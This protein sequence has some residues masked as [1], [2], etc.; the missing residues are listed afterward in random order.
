MVVELSPGALVAGRYRLD[1]LLGRGG[2]GQVWAATH[3]VTHRVAAL[4]LLNGPVH[5]QAGRRR[6]FLREARAAS[7]VNHPNVVRV[8]DFFELED[9]TPVMIMDL[10]EGETLGRRLGR[11]G[12]LTLETAAGI[13]LPVVSAVGTA[14]A[15]GIIHRDLKPENVFLSTLSSGAPAVHVLDFG[16]A[17]LVPF[18]SPGSIDDSDALTG[19]GGLMGTP[20]Y[21][22]PEQGFGEG[23]V[24]HRT[25][26]WS[27]GI[28]LY[29]ALAGSRPV[30]GANVGQVLKRLLS[31][32]ITPIEVLVSDL[33][34]EVS[35][36]V[37]RMLQ[38]DPDGRPRDLREVAAILSCHTTATAPPFEAAIGEAALSLDSSPTSAQSSPRAVVRAAEPSDPIAATDPVEQKVTVTAPSTAP[39]LGAVASQASAS[40][41]MRHRPLIALSALLLVVGLAAVWSLRSPAGSAAA[42]SSASVAP[43]AT[44]RDVPAVAAPSPVASQVEP[45]APVDGQGPEPRTATSSEGPERPRPPK[46]PVRPPRP[47]A[48][49]SAHHGGLVDKPPF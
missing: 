16:I 25:D 36:L 27:L 31:E 48:A 7:A 23:T 39:S 26:I 17:K 5:L 12:A 38:R 2:M 15:R 24:D 22:S 3:D 30:D 35:E 10:L 29:E 14:H 13:L 47:A 28:V 41:R 1:R 46:P 9:G 44:E 18:A 37:G 34:P 49:S 40:P 21:M 11:E 42:R 4:K 19:T 32:A 33:P 8:H 6:R 43:S 45:K 20:C